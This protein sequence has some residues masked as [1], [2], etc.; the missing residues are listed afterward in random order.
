MQY[1][2]SL[3]KFNQK[4]K[5]LRTATVPTNLVPKDANGAVNYVGGRADVKTGR[6]VMQCAVS[7][8]C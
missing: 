6:Q 2:P 5:L 3:Y 1:G 4:G 7:C 8:W